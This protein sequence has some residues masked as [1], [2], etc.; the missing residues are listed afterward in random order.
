MELAVD[1]SDLFSVPWNENDPMNTPTGLADPWDAVRKLETAAEKVKETYGSLDVMWGD[2]H[3]LRTEGIDLPANGGEGDPYGHFRVTYY[4]PIDN[5]QYMAVGG[6]S[7]VAAIE[8]S[9]P[10]KARALL[11][12][13]NASQPGTTH[14]TDQLSLYSEKKLRPVFLDRNVIENH[15]E[16]KD[17]F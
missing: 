17:I 2:V 10:V 1:K 9:N 13:G 5:N 8:F 7:Y 12:Y 14:K 16:S 6:D 3:R 15:L 4:H 11:S